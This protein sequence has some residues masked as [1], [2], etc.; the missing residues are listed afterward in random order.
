MSSRPRIGIFPR[1]D[2]SLRNIILG[3][4]YTDGTLAAG[5]VPSIMP[6]TSDRGLLD[7]LIDDYDGF[8]IP[9]GQDIDPSAYGQMPSP[10]LEEVS[11][12][13]D[14]ME[15]YLSP[16]IIA[17]D[18]PLLGVCR[19]LQ[20]VNVAM[21]GT[22][23]Q[24]LGTTPF[25]ENPIDHYQEPPYTTMVHTIDINPASLL[26]RLSGGTHIEVNSIHHQS[27]FDIAEG[28]VVS[29]F[30]SDGVVEAIEMPGMRFVL[31]VQWHPEYLWPTH[32]AQMELFRG[33]VAA[34][35]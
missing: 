3:S 35:R 14:D 34:C 23:I 22:L 10:N 18:K 29:A 27:A 2:A 30:A 32:K 28:F 21:G 25:I 6:L 16:K 8:I 17:A 24:D 13:R 31:G 4:G 12:Q 26:A 33:F 15:Y 5:G 11:P 19:G 7:Q 1:Y 20:M 9:G